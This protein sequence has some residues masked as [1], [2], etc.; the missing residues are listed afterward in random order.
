MHDTIKLK[1]GPR[2]W[3]RVGL[4]LL[5]AYGSAWL[6]LA[7][8]RLVPRMTSAEPTQASEVF[9]WVT[10]MTHQTL[11]SIQHRTHSL[12]YTGAFIACCA[13]LFALY[14]VMLWMARTARSRWFVPGAVAASVVFM[15][16]LACKPVMLSSDVYAY[17]HYGHMLGVDGVDAHGPPPEHVAKDPFTLSGYYDFVP[18]VYGPLWTLISAG[19]VLAA[20]SQLG[21]TVLLFRGLEVAA[22]LGSS[23]LIWLTLKQ[24]A[25][26]RTQEGL[27][28]FLW[29]PLVVAETALGGHN[30]T[31][32]M[33]LALVAVWLHVRG[34]KAGAV[35]ALV[36]SALVKV[37]TWPLV[38]LYILMVLRSNR[39]WKAGGWFVM[40]AGLGAAAVMGLSVFLARMSPD[41]L[42]A[43]T[44]SS[45]QFY[46]NNYHELLFK[47]VRRLLGEPADSM[48]APMDFKTWW[49][50]TNSPAILHAGISNKSG[51]LARLKANQQLLVTSDEDSDDWLRVYDPVDHVQGYV[52][53]NHLEVID[54]PANADD[55]PAVARLS[56]YPPEDWPTVINANR[57]IRLTTWALFVAFGLL[58]AWKTT[59]FDR[60]ILWSTGF[61]LA[62][63]LLVFTKI[64]P[65]Y[66]IWPLAFGALKPRSS[67]TRLAI[68]LSAGMVTLYAFLDYTNT[69]WDWVYECR[70]IPTIVLPV[71]LFAILK[72]S[73]L[74]SRQSVV[75]SPAGS[76]P[77]VTEVQS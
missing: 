27:V 37:I 18:S 75:Y 44:A 73:G 11:E 23:G 3:L 59:D 36:L 20:K 68:M 39:D 62:S 65:W 19:L 48:G 6:Y 29:N 66:G 77:V 21:L 31:C 50:A 8:A 63:Q 46:E 14:G 42:T 12:W 24:L 54:E 61:F 17:S 49:V 41:G 28:L 16:L 74:F 53:W 25:P 38:P 15:G 76:E 34:W 35:V 57:I 60:F 67:P 7:M 52:D 43:R 40:R 13:G 26:E 33:F 22:A 30:D 70:S 9:R 72:F 4:V 64:W 10:P 58:A 56:G 71:V 2:H 45:A 5:C 51:D 32:M 69:P 55:D 1:P 47:G